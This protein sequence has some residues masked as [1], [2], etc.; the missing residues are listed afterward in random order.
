MGWCRQRLVSTTTTLVLSA[1]VV[2]CG[3]EP[4]DAVV[5]ACNT[6]RRAAHSTSEWI[7][8]GPRPD[9]PDEATMAELEDHPE[10]RK[11]IGQV[12]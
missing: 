8:G 9:L 5:T 4:P 12:E 7:R 6:M 11:A 1:G 3:Q 2:G 10:L